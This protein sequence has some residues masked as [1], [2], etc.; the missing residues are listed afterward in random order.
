MTEL[1]RSE[2]LC[3]PKRRRLVHDK[4]KGEEGQETLHV[5]YGE[6]EIVFDEPELLPF[7]DK[8]LASERFRAEEAMS[9]SLGAPHDWEKVRGLLEALID[10]EILKR[11]SDAEPAPVATAFPSTLGTV[12]V[13]R[14]PR[15]FS[16][17]GQCPMITKEAFGVSV[18][19]GNLEVLVPIYRVA[20]P[21][22]DQDGRQ[23]GE[24]NVSPRLLFLDLPTQ[25]RRCGYAG[26]RYQAEL[27]MN[28]TALKHMTSR[29]PELLSL[30]EQ[31]RA[32]VFARLPGHGASLRVGEVHLL[33]VCTLAVAGY[34]MVRGEEPVPNGQL[35]AGLAAIFRLIDGV[36]LVT[37]EMMR[38]TAG[39]HGC[40]LP[41]GAGAIAAYAEQHAVYYGTH[42]V[43]AGPQALIEEYLRVMTG[44]ASAPIQV[45]P[46]V[47]TRVG[48][49][50][51]ALDYGLLGQRVESLVRAFGA[52]QGLLHERLRVALEGQAPGSRLREL[53]L[54]PIDEANTPQLRTEHPLRETHEQEI[55]INRWLF[56]RAGEAVSTEAKVTSATLDALFALDTASQAATARRLACFFAQLEGDAPLGD[57]A[58]AELAAVAAETFA[59]ERRC[60]RAVGAE[61]RRL[62]ERLKREPGR[63][64]VGEDL[65]AY[66]RP[67][68]GPPLAETLAAAFGLTITTDADATV[69]RAGDL[70]LSL[71]D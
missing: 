60:L 46:D 53:V 30:T 29:W 33:A 71:T 65:A 36:R 67:R 57:A 51:A 31:F 18:D 28:V 27:P 59:L 17:R 43:C 70:S 12:P 14:A 48:D 11:V 54:A 55:A 64:L 19:A 21:A 16:D 1:Q 68:S 45:T 69:L 39:E 13:G 4:R 41:I 5:F 40:D 50:S 20:H 23:L 42:G 52:R 56:A 34:V 32:A 2:I 10:V 38:A 66:T 22:M 49:L 7:G 15:V 62:N 35:D 37:T 63:A 9:W 24:N 3:V 58:R 8:L 44:E 25:R 47:A 61:Q 26:S 6:K